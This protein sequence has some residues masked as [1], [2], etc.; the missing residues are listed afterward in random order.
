MRKLIAVS[1]VSVIKRFVCKLFLFSFVVV[2][3]VTYM[4]IVREH[5]SGFLFSEYA[6]VTF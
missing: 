6:C 3:V 1:L 5:R 2:V 4:K